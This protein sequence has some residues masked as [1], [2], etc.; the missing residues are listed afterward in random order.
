M[1]K[2]VSILICFVLS[3]EMAFAQQSAED[4]LIKLYE[5]DIKILKAKIDSLNK[6]V[7]KPLTNDTASLG[8]KLRKAHKDAG[9]YLQ[10][11]ENAERKRDEY[12]HICDSLIGLLKKHPA[13]AEVT[14]LRNDS[15]TLA[16]SL[17]EAHSLSIELLAEKDKTISTLQQELAN[18][19][20]FK[21][22]FIASLA[23][24][25]DD[26]W[27]MLS[28]SELEQKQQEL[29][30]DL[31]LYEKF[32]D[33][34]AVATAYE[35]LKQLNSDFK[36][37]LAAKKILEE[38]PYDFKEVSELIDKTK[39][40][41]QQ[42]SN[43][44]RPKE[45]QALYDLLSVYTEAVN[46]FKYIIKDINNRNAKDKDVIKRRLETRLNLEVESINRIK[47]LKNKF[48]EYYEEIISDASLT[49]PN[50]KNS[51]AYQINSLKTN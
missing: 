30:A 42:S 21:E 48:D 36:I 47:W 19:Q 51:I 29:S 35:K 37:Y 14:R 46:D 13:L 8:K 32:K 10:D 26:K 17:A 33:V 25:V 27:L 43:S 24:G 3:A 28:F 49:D 1:K 6:K 31:A 7:I 4:K 44:V 40:I 34:P 2:I 11:K 16:D 20:D 45:M 41:A 23:N 18:L 5:E 12:K 22:Q 38:G 15:I 39:A 50:N 9:E